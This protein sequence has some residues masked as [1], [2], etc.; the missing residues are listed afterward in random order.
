MKL[1][2]TRT[3]VVIVALMVMGSLTACGADPVGDGPTT[4][5]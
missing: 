1:Y 2:R 3:S 5:S 4:A